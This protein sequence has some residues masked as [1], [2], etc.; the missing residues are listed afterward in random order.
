MPYAKNTKQ[1]LRG[2]GGT[3]AF[4][5]RVQEP[6]VFPQQLGNDL[7][8]SV[9]LQ[10]TTEPRH[11]LPSG[12]LQKGK[13]ILKKHFKLTFWFMNFSHLPCKAEPTQEVIAG[14]SWLERTSQSYLVQPPA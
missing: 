6:T 8:Y 12:I 4:T 1:A 5:Y 3:A 10:A 2:Y 14:E 9:T 13:L 7:K 11:R